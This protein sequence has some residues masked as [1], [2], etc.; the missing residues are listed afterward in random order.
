MMH[1]LNSYIQL[2][3]MLQPEQSAADGVADDAREGLCAN[4]VET[5]ETGQKKITAFLD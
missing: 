2:H 5:H 1:S 3:L 4:P